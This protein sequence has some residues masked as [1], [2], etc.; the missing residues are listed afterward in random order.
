MQPSF[1]RSVRL[2]AIRA[3]VA[4]LVLAVTASLAMLFAPQ[5]LACDTYVSGYYRADGTYVSGHYRSCSNSTTSDNWT[6]RGNVN[7]YT[8][9][10]GYRSP[11]YSSPSRCY[12]SWSC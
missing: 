10:P 4:T 1:R 5:A 3:G 2:A 11:S 12:F 8:G 6:T 9:E 7:A